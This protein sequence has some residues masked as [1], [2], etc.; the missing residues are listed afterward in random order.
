MHRRFC[1]GPQSV[2]VDQSYQPGRDVY[3]TNRL[4]APGSRLRVG[5]LK[6]GNRATCSL[7]PVA[8]SL[9]GKALSHIS[10]IG[11]RYSSFAAVLLVLVMASIPAQAQTLRGR[12]TTYGHGF[13][14]PAGSG[15]ATHLPFYELVELHASTPSVEGLSVHAQVWGMV[16]ALDLQDQNRITGDV[17]TLYLD[18]RVP[19]EGRLSF[20]HGM[21]LTA[22]RQLVALGPAV[23]EQVDGGKLHYVHSSGVEVGVFGGAPT[24]IRMIYSPW[25]TDE[26]LYEYGYNWLVGGRLG[27]V[28]LGWLSG[29]V[30]YVHRR[31]D[32][33]VAD[34][35]LG[36]DVSYSPLSW[37]DLVGHVTLSLEATRIKQGRAS[38]ALRPWRRWAFNLGYHH[39]SPDLWVPRTSIFAVFSEESFHEGSVDARWRVTRRLTLDAVYGRRFFGGQ[40]YQSTGDDLAAART[41]ANRASLRASYRPGFLEG[42]RVVAEAGRL[43]APTNAANRLRLASSVP[44]Y[45][46]GRTFRLVADV[47]LMVLDEPL[48]DSQISVIGSGY[49]EAPILRGLR[50]LAG[51]SGGV[52]PLLSTMGSFTVRLTWDF[53]VSRQK[54]GGAA[55]KPAAVQVRRGSLL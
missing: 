40:E 12:S 39:S 25:P 2:S 53:D 55:A 33:G 28:N 27:Y 17:T 50:L 13:V 23:L 52:S 34:S 8:C 44:L 51:G 1:I 45:L 47:D 48:R 29:G 42:A 30:S 4:R 24:G 20:L 31:Y 14:Q 49:L 9:C 54:G 3:R 16:D 36:A 15:T 18:Y 22:G 21:K 26:D 35:D 10:R 6:V 46:L 7:Q 37:L 43:E 32:G 19:A 11:I 41:S 5:Q 38:V